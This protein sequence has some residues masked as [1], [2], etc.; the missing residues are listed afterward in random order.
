MP[1]LTAGQAPGREQGYF[2]VG[3]LFEFRMSHRTNGEY[4]GSF[5]SELFFQEIGCGGA[6]VGS[7][8]VGNS[9]MFIPV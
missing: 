3:I 2:I 5:Q 9:R 1:A 8:Q 6:D 7:A 4:F